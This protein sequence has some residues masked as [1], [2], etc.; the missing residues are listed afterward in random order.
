VQ[1]VEED[2]T[3]LDVSSANLTLPNYGRFARDLGTILRGRL[4][5]LGDAALTTGYSD[6]ADLIAQHRSP[7]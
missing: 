1:H 3:I 2:V 6:L 4:I 7:S 5:D